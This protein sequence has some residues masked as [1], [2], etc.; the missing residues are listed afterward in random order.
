MNKKRQGRNLF[1]IQL[2]GNKEQEKEEKFDNEYK[3]MRTNIIL[4][5][6]KKK[7][8]IQLKI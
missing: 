8:K 2:R 6:E 1:S 7:K 4:I 3:K 5:R